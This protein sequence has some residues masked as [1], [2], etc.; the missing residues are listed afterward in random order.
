MRKEEREGEADC[1]EEGDGD[2][3]EGEA[4]W[5]AAACALRVN[6]RAGDGHPQQQ[7]A[8]PPPACWLIAHEHIRL[9]EE[10]GW[11]RVVGVALRVLDEKEQN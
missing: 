4:S 2:V 1:A 8:R 11:I 10:V 3:S 9:D 6:Q 7:H 5:H